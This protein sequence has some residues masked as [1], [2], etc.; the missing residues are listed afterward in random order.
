MRGAAREPVAGAEVGRD[1]CRH[2]HPGDER[3]Q[4]CNCNDHQDE[5]PHTWRLPGH[6]AA[7]KGAPTL[8]PWPSQGQAG[9]LL[10]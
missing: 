4:A 5:L 9:T 2:V 7:A 3:R 6:R 1:V 8:I 10:Q